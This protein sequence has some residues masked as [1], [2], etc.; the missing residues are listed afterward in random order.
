MHGAIMTNETIGWLRPG[1][2]TVYE[3]PQRWYALLV[4]SGSERKVC[5]WLKR[6]QFSPYWAR[7]RGQ[8]KLNRH[9]KAI[10]WRSVIPG[11]LFIPVPVFD[12]INCELVESAPGARKM[13]KSGEKLV[14]IPEMGKDGIEQIKAIEAA[15]NASAVAASEGIP[16]KVGQQIRIIKV[17]I[18][19][20]INR[21]ASKTKIVVEAMMFGAVRE[22]EL[23]VSEIEAV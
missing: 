17:E 3:I 1:D 13:M 14:E 22:W 11:Y 6:R 16:F 20:K 4:E 9:R 18:E 8:V 5:I 2:P 19:G 23:P 15:L 10:R 21:I 12:T 7:Y